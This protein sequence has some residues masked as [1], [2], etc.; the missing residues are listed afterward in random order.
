MHA[1]LVSLRNY[2]AK[3]VRLCL[4]WAATGGFSEFMTNGFFEFLTIDFF[5]EFLTNGFFL[6]SWLLAF[7][8]FLTNGFFLNSWLMAFFWIHGYW[9]FSD[10]L[11][12]V[13]FWIPDS[14]TFLQKYCTLSQQFLNFH[15][16]IVP[17]IDGADSTVY[18]C[19]LGQIWCTIYG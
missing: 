4:G 17:V 11:T 12:N 1:M 15:I 8:E 7:S 10:F 9:L 14:W 16:K 18:V 6:N 3:F 13:F 5:S 19:F 2:F